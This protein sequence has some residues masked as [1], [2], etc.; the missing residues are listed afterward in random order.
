MSG[1]IFTKTKPVVYLNIPKAGCSTIKN[2]LY[3]IDNQKWLSNPLDIHRLY[4]KELKSI[5][6]MNQIRSKHEFF[7]F[8]FVRHPL[9]RN[10]SL[11][12]EKILQKTP[13][14]FPDKVFNIL[15][16]K[17]GIDLVSEST[18]ELERSNYYKFLC[19]VEDTVTKKL[20]M[21]ADPHWKPQY[22]ILVQ[23]RYRGVDFVGK[24]ENFAQ[25]FRFVLDKIGVAEPL[26]NKRFNENAK[27]DF[28]YTQ[29]LTPK[30]IE[31]GNEIYKK[32]FEYFGYQKI[33][34]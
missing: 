13:Y 10:Y 31:L 32:D 30:I 1:Y 16:K 3:Y 22:D 28:N 21:P 27:K 9:K 2:C 20:S 8:T 17:Y 15:E 6:D 33:K 11:Y 25:D 26:E 18:L 29:V 34:I 12:Q 5:F 24:L 7:S 4:P 23:E 19:F 14:S